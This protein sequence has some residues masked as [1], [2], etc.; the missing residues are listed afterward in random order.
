MSLRQESRYPWF[1]PRLV[2][3]VV[4]AIAVVWS[5][6]LVTGAWKTNHDTPKETHT[7]D[8]SGSATRHLQPDKLTWTITV[9]ATGDTTESATMALRS[10][11]S[12]LHDYLLAHNIQDSE[13]TYKQEVNET[14][15]TQNGDEGVP[16]VTSISASQEV[17][18]DPS[19]IGRGLEAQ[20]AASATAELS[21]VQI[22]EAE[23][24]SKQTDALRDQL[25]LEARANV[26]AN[27]RITMGQF[28][29][30]ELG[31]VVNANP[32]S[33]DVG[34]D[35]TDIVMTATAGATYEIE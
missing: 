32:G 21:D 10:N 28:H 30:G 2:T 24:T 26:Y 8:V 20:R 7:I 11:V 15:S 17:E 6:F 31:R 4:I 29:G 27:A 34:A 25:L 16:Q 23:C 22:G 19:N 3:P 14:D 18:V 1:E 12:A 5:T 13:I 35:C 33:V 9:H